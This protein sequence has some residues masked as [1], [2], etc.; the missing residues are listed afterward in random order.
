MH[1]AG[2]RRQRRRQ[3]QSR[4]SSFA[5]IGEKIRP[6]PSMPGVGGV[7]ALWG[8]VTPAGRAAAAVSLGVGTGDSTSTD[9]RTTATIPRRAT[10]C[11]CLQ[12]CVVL[13]P[14]SVVRATIPARYVEVLLKSEFKCQVNNWERSCSPQHRPRRRVAQQAQRRQRHAEQD[15][16][17]GGHALHQAYK[18]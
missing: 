18:Y 16:V 15:A 17:K 9:A 8:R 10:R 6:P 14:R 5:P 4:D 3:R 11:C 12:R 7:L 2:E 1:S 13:Q